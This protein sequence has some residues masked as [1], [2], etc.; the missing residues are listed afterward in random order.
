MKFRGIFLIGCCVVLV[1]CTAQIV[2][3][4][5]TQYIN[6]SFTARDLE[7]GGLALLPV[8]A[9]QGQEGF[10]RPLGDL[11]NLHLQEAVPNGRVLTWQTTMDSINAKGM[12]DT[13]E[14]LIN[15]YQK[16]SIVNR[17]R[18]RELYTA[19]GVRY[20]L[21]CSLQDY[22]ENTKTSYN[23]FSGLNTT[24][25]ANVMAQ[26]LVLDLVTGDV[27]QEIIGQ[28]GS[29]AGDLMR[30]SPYEAYASVIANSVLSQ[31]PGSLV[32]V[33]ESL[34]QNKGTTAEGSTPF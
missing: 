18:V 14:Q 10:R 15:G 6:E 9:G 13:Y 3:M 16:T 19:L 17:E 8:T 30:N 31:L 21:Y 4:T 34:K 12:V 32:T 23:L 11:L 27:A 22:S 24:K 5:R 20:A 2:N 7:S 29:V 1:G 25:T 33:D 26:C 28:A